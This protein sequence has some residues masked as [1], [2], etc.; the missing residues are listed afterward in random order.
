MRSTLK[1][2]IKL[3]LAEK[4]AALALYLLLAILPFLSLLVTLGSGFLS[5]P[6]VKAEILSVI[7]QIE[8]N[9][10]ASSFEQLLDTVRPVSAGDIGI[11][12]FSLVI[13]LFGASGIFNSLQN[14]YLQIFTKSGKITAERSFLK[15]IEQYLISLLMV[16][17]TVFFIVIMFVLSPVVSS[18]FAFLAEN[19]FLAPILNV[20]FSVQIVAL[21]LI[22]AVVAILFK[23]LSRGVITWGESF[24]GGLVTSVV[25]AL[26]SILLG[27][28][29]SFSISGSVFSLAT[30]LTVLVTW[31]NIVSL[32]I[33]LGVLASTYRYKI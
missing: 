8:S 4:A 1:K 33:I 2:W 24:F 18:G 30:I 31:L 11:V 10:L 28:Y 13:L 26:A 17:A 23:V 16:L 12:I 5:S 22:A 3:E 6:R 9:F 20:L 21:L 15:L 14:W 19:T 27:A 29:F 7:N 32:S 25:N